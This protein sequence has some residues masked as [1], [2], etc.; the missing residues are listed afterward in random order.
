MKETKDKEGSKTGKHVFILPGTL[1]RGR[2]RGLSTSRS[3][4]SSNYIGSKVLIK[5][6]MKKE[7]VKVHS[8]LF[9]RQQRGWC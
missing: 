9:L 8:V 7:L 5:E 1:L 2:G 4:C 6:K 3:T